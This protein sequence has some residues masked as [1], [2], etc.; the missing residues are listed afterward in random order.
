MP[1]LFA[2]GLGPL[3]FGI[4]A[5]VGGFLAFYQPETNNR[6]IPETINEANHFMVTKLV[7]D[8]PN[9]FWKQILRN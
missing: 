7:E 8:K 3:I 9:N 6:K 1:T 2:E 5:L 4:A